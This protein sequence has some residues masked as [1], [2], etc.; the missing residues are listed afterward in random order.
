MTPWIGCV[1]DHI[2]AQTLGYM[3]VRRVRRMSQPDQLRNGKI[4]NYLGPRGTEFLEHA[5]GAVPRLLPH[6]EVQWYE[7]DQHRDTCAKWASSNEI[8]INIGIGG[9]GESLARSIEGVVTRKQTGRG[10]DNKKRSLDT[11]EHAICSAMATRIRGL[12]RGQ[13]PDRELAEGEQLSL[14][15]IQAKFDEQVVAAYLK[16]HHGIQF[17]VTHA[18]DAVHKL[19]ELTYENKSLAF[20]ALIDGQ[21]EDVE[22]ESVFPDELLSRKKFRALTDGYKTAYH[23]C[24]RGS[25]RA[26]VDLD[27]EAVS[28]APPRYKN[29]PFWAESLA[30]SSRGR[31]CGLSLTRQGDLLVFDEG[32]LKLSY[33]FGS[34]QYWNHAHLKFILKSLL[35]GKERQPSQWAR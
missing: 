18:L 1:Y 10:F 16:T 4:R 24:S 23:V 27:A 22:A 5:L 2:P 17:D 25:L 8:Y 14:A 13:K 33:R 31:V 12:L 3:T 20:G 7:V 6:T 15:A 29:Y 28:H 32:E 26:I 30:R 35:R 19:G 21:F 34:W 9:K 11:R